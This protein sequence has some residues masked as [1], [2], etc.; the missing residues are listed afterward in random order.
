MSKHVPLLRP[1]VR[2]S[3][4]W[5][6]SANRMMK[7]RS[8]RNASEDQAKMAKMHHI[9]LNLSQLVMHRFRNS[10]RRSLL[11]GGG[12]WYYPLRKLVRQNWK[13]LSKSGRPERTPKPW[14]VEAA[15]LPEICSV[16]MKVSTRHGWLGH[17]GRH[18]NVSWINRLG[19]CSDTDCGVKLYFR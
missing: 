12:N 13:T 10:R 6:T 8:A 3:V 2:R 5:K 15:K 4:G 11:V 1:S 7:S 17:P 9:R 19:G 18:L 14:L 16:I